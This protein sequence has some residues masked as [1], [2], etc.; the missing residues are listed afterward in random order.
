MSELYYYRIKI[1]L[2]TKFFLCPFLLFLLMS[3]GFAAKAA[4][5]NSISGEIKNLPKGVL[6]LILEE[7]INRKKSRRTL[8]GLLLCQ[9][10]F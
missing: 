4:A 9:N 6:Q 10:C 3:I 2:E 7:D 1:M 8:T 5:Q